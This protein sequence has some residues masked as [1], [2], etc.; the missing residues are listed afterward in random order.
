[1]EIEF[2]R[3]IS[4]RKIFMILVSTKLYNHSLNQILETSIEKISFMLRRFY[5]VHFVSKETSPISIESKKRSSVL[6]LN[7]F[8][9]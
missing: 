2:I 8:K 9:L 1:M 4:R 3:I 7:F 6:P 5:I